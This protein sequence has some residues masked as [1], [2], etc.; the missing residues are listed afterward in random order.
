MAESTGTKLWKAFQALE[1]PAEQRVNAP[2]FNYDVYYPQN[3]GNN[4]F[5]SVFDLNKVSESVKNTLLD[6]LKNARGATEGPNQWA[7]IHENGMLVVDDEAAMKWMNSDTN[8]RM[9][10]MGRGFKEAALGDEFPYDGKIA[11]QILSPGAERSL[12]QGGEEG[13]SKQIFG[14]IVGE[15][16]PSK[17]SLL[18]SKKSY[19]PKDAEKIIR[20]IRS[21]G[22]NAGKPF[23]MVA[24]ED[25]TMRL[26]FDMEQVVR[27]PDR[28][29]SIRGGTFAQLMEGTPIMSRDA[30]SKGLG[31]AFSSSLILDKGEIILPNLAV[32]KEIANNPDRIPDQN[33]TKPRLV[34]PKSPQRIKGGLFT[35]GE[36][37]EEFNQ[38]EADYPNQ[39]K[40]YQT[41]LKENG[42]D[43]HF[44]AMK[45]QMDNDRNPIALHGADGKKIGDIA[46]DQ[47]ETVKPRQK[48]APRQNPPSPGVEENPGPAKPAVQIDASEQTPQ[49]PGT[50]APSQPKPIQTPASPQ[51]PPSKTAPAPSAQGSSPTATGQNPPSYTSPP[52]PPPIAKPAAAQTPAGGQPAQSPN[53]P[54]PA[55]TTSYP[56]PPPPPIA[57]KP[58]TQPPADKIA[59]ALEVQVERLIERAATKIVN[60]KPVVD[61]GVANALREQIDP[62]NLVK[63]IRKNNVPGSVIE[64]TEKLGGIIDNPDNSEVHTL[65]TMMT[66]PGNNPGEVLK[67]DLHFQKFDFEEKVIHGFKTDK[68]IQTDA[69]EYWEKNERKYTPD[70]TVAEIFSEPSAGPGRPP[71]KAPAQSAAPATGDDG[72][73]SPKT[74]MARELVGENGK[75]LTNR[76]VDGNQVLRIAANDDEGK[77]LLGEMGYATHIA[78]KEKASRAGGKEKF[79]ELSPEKT[80]ELLKTSGVTLQPPS[81]VKTPKTAPAQTASSIAGDDPAAAR[82]RADEQKTRAQT[83]VADGKNIGFD[84]DDRPVLLIPAEN[85]ELRRELFTR[86]S[87]ARFADDVDGA[88]ATKRI[89]GEAYYVIPADKTAALLQESGHGNAE[90]LTQVRKTLKNYEAVD[91]NTTKGDGIVF[92]GDNLEVLAADL[93]K[94]GI[95]AVV[96]VDKGR[97]RVKTTSV[98]QGQIIASESVDVTSPPSGNRPG[99]STSR[100]LGEHHRFGPA[101]AREPRSPTDLNVSVPDL[102]PE[103]ALRAKQ[104]EGEAPRQPAPLSG[105]DNTP[106][107]KMV[108]LADVKAARDSLKPYANSSDVNNDGRGIV[109]FG[110]EDEL[111]ATRDKLQALGIESKVK[112]TVVDTG[113]GNVKASQLNIT[114]N[115]RDELESFKIIAPDGMK[116]PDP[117]PVNKGL[118]PSAERQKAIDARSKLYPEEYR[119]DGARLPAN[120]M[121]GHIEKS[122]APQIGNAEAPRQQSFSPDEISDLQNRLSAGMHVDGEFDR[123]RAIAD[124]EKLT[125]LKIHDAGN[126]HNMEMAQTL[127]ALTVQKT[128]PDILFS[129]EILPNDIKHVVIGHG[130]GEAS[131]DWRFVDTNESVKDFIRANVPDG[132]KAL[133]VVCSAEELGQFAFIPKNKVAVVKGAGVEVASYEASRP[134][135]FNTDNSPAP[136][137]ESAEAPKQKLSPRAMGGQLGAML[138]EGSIGNDAKNGSKPYADVADTEANRAAL[139]AAGINIG[140]ELPDAKNGPKLRIDIS[141]DK[142]SRLLMAYA[143]PDGDAAKRIQFAKDHQSLRENNKPYE[144]ITDKVRELRDEVRENPGD[145]AAA[146]DLKTAQK[147]AKK[148]YESMLGADGQVDP[149][150][151]ES[152]RKARDDFPEKHKALLDKDTGNPEY[153]EAVEKVRKIKEEV[154]ALNPRDPFE[155]DMLDEANAK[156][157]NAQTEAQGIYKKATQNPTTPNAPE[158]KPARTEEPPVSAKPAEPAKNAPE[159]SG[160]TE[161]RTPSSADTTPQASA[162]E[163]KSPGKFIVGGGGREGR[164]GERFKTA[165]RPDNNSD[166][167]TPDIRDDM[168]AN[169]TA[170]QPAKAPA[171]AP[172]AKSAASNEAKPSTME[173]PADAKN[174]SAPA[175]EA[176]KQAASNKTPS[177]DANTH[178]TG[179]HSS[180]SAGNHTHVTGKL[181]G[182]AGVAMGINGLINGNPNDRVSST[183][184]VTDA[185]VNTAQYGAEVVGDMAGAAKTAAPGLIKDAAGTA[186][187][188]T[189]ALKTAGAATKNIASTAGTILGHTATVVMVADGINQTV[190]AFKENGSDYV[191]AVAASEKAL[192]T[193][194]VAIGGTL[195]VGA[196]GAYLGT[197]AVG[198]AAAAEIAAVTAGGVGALTVGGAGAVVAVAAAPVVATVAVAA[199]AGATLAG[200]NY[201]GARIAEGLDVGGLAQ[202]QKAPAKGTM[203]AAQTGAIGA[204]LT[205]DQLKNDLINDPRFANLKTH[206]QNSGKKLDPDGNLQEQ[207]SGLIKDMK[208][209]TA[210]LE[211]EK[212]YLTWGHN[213]ELDGQIAKLTAARSELEDY[214][215]IRNVQD[216]TEKAKAVPAESPSSA[217]AQ[218]QPQAVAENPRQPAEQPQSPSENSQKI[219]YVAAVQTAPGADLTKAEIAVIQKDG[220]LNATVPENQTVAKNGAANKSEPAK[221]A[222]QPQAAASP[223]KNIGEQLMDMVDTNRDGKVTIQEIGI[224]AAG[225]SSQLLGM[226]IAPKNLENVQET[227]K[228]IQNMLQASGMKVD[229]NNQTAGNTVSAPAVAGAAK[230]QSH[231]V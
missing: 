156:L 22:D 42:V 115:S 85:N 46:P 61:G 26:G 217:P 221:A 124:V 116:M 190:N 225:M 173:A 52:P 155:R 95:E 159:P 222:P 96:E 213:K 44:G 131:G 138:D 14:E 36:S 12:K 110:K 178:T 4:N 117:P 187:T 162:P 63:E 229:L 228:A 145:A 111:L 164:P 231:T 98:E 77:R 227:M 195:A 149:E 218:S 172:A 181:S 169:K 2:R 150:K 184:A 23:V 18:I 209:K 101:G 143:N 100:D 198:L 153:Q 1:L 157:K 76:S 122:V 163:K 102:E 92:K 83:L 60:G 170:S 45:T 201:V 211:G 166:S 194:A 114:F 214:V 180:H 41:K 56:P 99:K 34:E 66:K 86:D 9:P 5:I 158:N 82:N 21:Q 55:T 210:K 126:T 68:K 216:A 48:T 113:D 94:I 206:L 91:I 148:I 146:E 67:I 30:R 43:D 80:A 165:Y 123:A 11:K 53:G 132:Q 197:T 8:N 51:S 104:I 75:N 10:N 70:I 35:K 119:P 160:N 128:N 15:L 73:D 154:A 144:N 78:P 179:S 90:E 139:E 112:T 37:L 196:V 147:Q 79:W 136:Q 188:A 54:K 105:Q 84:Q 47:A 177:A 223:K 133:C 27:S 152:Q 219:T 50:A 129:N 25:G 189:T 175:P 134:T 57:Q 192:E 62:P 226:G 40:Q 204:N 205:R 64:M 109:L 32:F 59:A 220:S 176:V 167:P 230:N 199:A 97:V 118:A 103:D 161:T 137:I 142:T 171:E 88:Y 127:T 20:A 120:Q 203:T 207:V 19:E 72:P 49:K 130:Q 24:H 208:D 121:P 29:T 69:R 151:V 200:A 215:S 17:G 39:L 3:M 74:A 65:I 174:N 13:L 89:K 135:A 141:D 6:T 93:N 33:I 168:A 224:A 185:V 108:S 7:Y 81:P 16:E 182:A 202:D 212:G 186:K 107:E 31:E 28:A 106:P 191:G 183:I 38:R 71:K 125:G 87:K 140:K 193:A 58:Q